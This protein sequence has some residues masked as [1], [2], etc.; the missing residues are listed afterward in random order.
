MQIM[1]EFGIDMKPILAAAG[2]VGLAVGFEAQNLVTAFV[3]SSFE[4]YIANMYFIPKALFRWH[5]CIDSF[6]S[7]SICR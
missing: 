7:S 6:W 4:H 2:I 1:S 3:A 5:L